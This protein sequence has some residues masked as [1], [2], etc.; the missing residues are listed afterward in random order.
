MGEL[1]KIVDNFDLLIR[2]TP[3]ILADHEAVDIKFMN[4]QLQTIKPNK[5]E[6]IPESLTD[7]IDGV[8]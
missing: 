3:R 2:E 4:G 1:Q 5:D 8:E 6:D 7:D